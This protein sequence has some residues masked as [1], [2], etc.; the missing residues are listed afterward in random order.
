[1]MTRNKKFRCL[2]LAAFLAIGAGMIW[3]MAFGFS[4]GVLHSIVYRQCVN[5]RL[6]YTHDGVPVI[7]SY[8]GRNYDSRTYRTLDGEPMERPRRGVRGYWAYLQTIDSRAPF[9]RPTWSERITQLGGNGHERW[10]FIC[11]GNLHGHCYMVGYDE[12][13]KGKIGYLD[14]KGFRTD[15][16]PLE[17]QFPI[18]GRKQTSGSLLFRCS[19]YSNWQPSTTYL[20]TKDGL[21]YV[22][23]KKRIVKLIWKG[24]D[25]FSGT[26]AD[27]LQTDPKTMQDQEA[28]SQSVLIRT[29]DRVLVYDSG[30]QK[31]QTYLL[32]AELRDKAFALIPLP[33]GKALVQSNIHQKDEVLWIDTTGKIVKRSD[34]NLQRSARIS[35]TTESLF[36]S[37]CVP[38]VGII[39]GTL[40]FY[41]WGPA[42]VNSWSL[43]YWVALSKGIRIWWPGLLFVS[44]LSVVLAILCYR[45]QR[46]Y[47]LEWT[48]LWVGFVFLFGLPAYF[49]YLAHRRW[50]ARLP[51]PNCN[52]LAPRDREACFSCHQKFPEPAP[53]GT[54]VF[55]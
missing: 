15:K 32:P 20:V 11:D 53:N 17:E 1:M 54:E 39:G 35:D 2:A 5:E 6:T 23:S 12:K 3:G 36:V 51:C 33:D 4:F 16:P 38:S 37:F 41:P 49:G 47:G 7:E 46:K 40:I 44:T 50:P 19:Q 55:A 42:S 14:R 52:N 26:I 27:D 10:F 9:F 28:D 24:T 30:G 34:V 13:S 31:I 22:S 21:F 45:R 25:L 43:G 8:E 29:P 18:D 48:W